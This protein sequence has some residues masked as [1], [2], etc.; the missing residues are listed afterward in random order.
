[1]R[2]TRQANKLEPFSDVLKRQRPLIPGKPVEMKEYEINHPKS[3]GDP[4][5]GAYSKH[6]FWYKFE[7]GTQDDFDQMVAR[8]FESDSYLLNYESF[9]VWRNIFGENFGFTVAKNQEGTVMGSVGFVV[10]DDVF[11][12]GLYYVMEEYRHSGI[13]YNLFQH[14]IRNNKSKPRI[15]HAMS[16]LAN[17][18]GRFGLHHEIPNGRTIHYIVENPAGFE[19]LRVPDVDIREISS[20]DL[21]AVASYDYSISKH[22]RRSWLNHWLKHEDSQTFVAFEKDVVVGYGNAREVAGGYVKRLLVGP[23]YADN[24]RVASSLLFNILKKYYNPEEDYEWDPDINAL[25]RRN[26]HFFIPEV[27]VSALEL[28]QI[29]CGE[30]GKLNKQRLHYEICCSETLPKMEMN[31]VFALSDLHLSVI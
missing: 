14:A 26:V 27:N 21:S 18:C 16:T 20:N 30:S 8:S 19:Q 3:C 4:W 24:Q 12:V 5:L 25:Y 1:M 31:K 22:A 7:E 10:Y 6:G 2:H 13:G 23:F 17:K 9:N 11:V 15:F 29:F 28:L